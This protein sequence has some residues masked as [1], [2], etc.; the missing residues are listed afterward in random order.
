MILS[1]STF[2]I[3]LFFI[4]VTPW[5]I[6]KTIWVLNSKKTIGIM[7]FVGHDNLGSV[8]GMSTYPV[9]QFKV[10]DSIFHFNGNMNLSLQKGQ[11]VEVRFQ[12]N[13]PGNARINSFGTIW[14][15][16]VAYGALPL[17]IYLVL[18]FSPG[19]IPWKSKIKIGGRAGIQ[20]INEP[21]TV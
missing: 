7:E 19:I 11:S 16:T 21:V 2:F 9:V 5:F 20:I 3:I 15:D 1:R 4:L 14:G 8:L 6:P 12:R 13:D 10:G 17:L 18:L